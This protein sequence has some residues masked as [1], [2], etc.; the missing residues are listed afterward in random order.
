MLIANGAD[1]NICSVP[2]KNCLNMLLDSITAENMENVLAKG[3]TIMPHLPTAEAIV[4]VEIARTDPQSSPQKFDLLLSLLAEFSDELYYPPEHVHVLPIPPSYCPPLPGTTTTV[5]K[6]MGMRVKNLS[7]V[8]LKRSIGESGESPREGDNEEAKE[9]AATADT[10]PPSTSSKATR[11][12]LTSS[13][14]AQEEE[15]KEGEG[16]VVDTSAHWRLKACTKDQLIR[17][18]GKFGAEK[19]FAH[20]VLL[21]YDE[22]CTPVE[23]LNN[24][25]SL[26]HTERDNAVVQRTIRS[27][28]HHWVEHQA[29]DLST[30]VLRRKIADLVGKAG[31]EEQGFFMSL[32]GAYENVRSP[33]KGAAM[34]VTDSER[35]VDKA[36]FSFSFFFFSN[37]F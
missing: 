17:A 18:I 8:S 28:L 32:E 9:R 14:S 6:R 2:G 22:Y 13:T 3:Q 10:N 35:C 12:V 31:I 27:F 5:E 37:S 23:L 29:S 11:L 15:G 7:E 25:F 19:C 4:E 16:E 34:G 30:P 21:C 33:R 26:Y 20:F 24:L 1:P 36:P